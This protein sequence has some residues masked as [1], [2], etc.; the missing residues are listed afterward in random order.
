V[1]VTA[2]EQHRIALLTNA[3]A[4]FHGRSH[5]VGQL[6]DVLAEVAR[7]GQVVGESG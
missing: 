3:P 2:A 7:H 1:V 4:A 5:P 6:I